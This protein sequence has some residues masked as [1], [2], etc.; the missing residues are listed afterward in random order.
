MTDILLESEG[1]NPERKNQGK[2][3]LASKTN[4]EIELKS[5]IN[6]LFQAF[7]TAIELANTALSAFP[8][9]PH[10]RSRSL[11]ANVMQ[12]CFANVMFSHF[13]DN[14]KFGKYKRL[15]IHLNGYIILF[16]KLNK[17][18]YP[19]NIKTINSK[20]ILAQNIVL[21]LF[22]KAETEEPILFFG[23][24]KN[25]F[26][27]YCDPQIVYIDE[28]TIQFTIT[29]SDIQIITPKKEDGQNDQDLQKAI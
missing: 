2:R 23:Y 29:E 4:C 14:T 28:G 15:I 17:K 20:S 6:M 24:K 12:S 21:E 11:E 25:K 7:N 22:S 10:C 8:F 26:G 9:P 27:V 3:Q 1:N 19:M 16:K 13:P 5:E 18:G